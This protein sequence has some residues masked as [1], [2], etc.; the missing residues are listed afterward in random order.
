MPVFNVGHHYKASCGCKAARS[1]CCFLLYHRSAKAL[2]TWQGSY[3]AAFN[4]AAHLTKLIYIFYWRLCLIQGIPHCK[5][6]PTGC[7]LPIFLAYLQAII[8]RGPVTWANFNR[9][10]L[11]DTSSI[12]IIGRF[13]HSHLQGTNTLQQC[14]DGLAIDSHTEKQHKMKKSEP[15]SA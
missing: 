8:L 4:A 11:V 10:L 12:H 14:A 9:N 6:W 13:V 3:V 5:V 7:K 1:F 2:H 15:V